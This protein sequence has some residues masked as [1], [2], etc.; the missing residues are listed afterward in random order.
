MP[1]SSPQEKKK[2]K[3]KKNPNNKQKKTP[4]HQEGQRFVMSS[5]PAAADHAAAQQGPSRDREAQEHRKRYDILTSSPTSLNCSKSWS[6]CLCQ[7]ALLL[8]TKLSESSLFQFNQRKENDSCSQIYA[9]ST[10]WLKQEKL[11]CVSHLLVMHHEW[12]YIQN[13]WGF[14]LLFLINTLSNYQYLNRLIPTQAFLE[15]LWSY[16]VYKPNT[17]CFPVEKPLKNPFTALQ[18]EEERCWSWVRQ[19]G[20][21]P[22]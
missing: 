6:N 1:S 8:K 13:P 14:L 20:L 2:N 5:Y 3:M 4:N 12:L 16:A 15:T 22:V 10:G 19:P 21:L 18:S 7:H 9:G 17:Y 11:A